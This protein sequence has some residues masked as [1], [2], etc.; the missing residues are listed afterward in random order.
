MSSG[1]GTAHTA[2]TKERLAADATL[3]SYIPR[4]GDVALDFQP[5]SRWQYSP[6]TGLDVVARI[7]EIVSGMDFDTFVRARIFEPLR[8]NDT[9]F[10]Y[11]MKSQIGG[12]PSKGAKSYSRVE[13]RRNISRRL[14][15]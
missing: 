13:V 12:S 9:H 5:G 1:L 2:N 7:I 11:Q 3:A 14:V 4:L 8:M 6:G 10:M 15:G